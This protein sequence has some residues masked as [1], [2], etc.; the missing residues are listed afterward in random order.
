M[1]IV[2]NIFTLSHSTIFCLRIVCEFLGDRHLIRN[3]SSFAAKDLAKDF[4][5][6]S[7]VNL[8][9]TSFYTSLIANASESNSLLSYLGMRL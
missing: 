5:S 6:S 9:L 1:L 7:A 2:K 8:L 3:H 4:C